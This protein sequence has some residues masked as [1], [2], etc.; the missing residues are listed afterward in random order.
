MQL[1]Y[2]IICRTYNLY[3]ISFLRCEVSCL[4]LYVSLPIYAGEVTTSLTRDYGLEKDMCIIINNII[5]K[6]I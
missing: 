6:K 2:I 3:F 4:T 1:L 5:N